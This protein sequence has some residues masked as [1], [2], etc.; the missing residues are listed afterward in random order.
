MA[1]VT[2]D[3]GK[4]YVPSD[5]ISRPG[6]LSDIKFS[7]IKTHFQYGYDIDPI[8][9]IR[10][11]RSGIRSRGSLDIRMGRFDIRMDSFG[12]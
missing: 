12:R 2:H 6:R 8:F 3:T 4:M 1:A 9:N 5:I 11:D 7:L 10:M